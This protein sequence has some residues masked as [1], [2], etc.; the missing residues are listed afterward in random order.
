M[1]LLKVT[2]NSGLVDL[3]GILEY[4]IDVVY[5]NPNISLSV[6]WSK[7]LD[8]FDELII[9]DS[10]INYINYKFVEPNINSIKIHAHDKTINKP[11][12]VSQMTSLFERYDSIE[13]WDNRTIVNGYPT[14]GIF[15]K[16]KF[17]TDVYKEFN[18]CKE[19]L[20]EHYIAFHGRF[21]DYPHSEEQIFLFKKQIN[22]V[23]E[24]T[25]SNVLLCTDNQALISEFSN[26]P[27]V[28][29]FS[30]IKHLLNEHINLPKNRGI[31]TFTEEQGINL[32]DMQKSAIIDFLMCIECNEFYSTNGGYSRT[33]VDIRKRRA[34]NNI[35]YK[36][37]NNL[38]EKI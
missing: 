10:N 17:T 33:I 28:Y 3:F 7:W 11:I 24:N 19:V 23:V 31:H 38:I 34:F 5:N 13:L 20:G 27:R 32:Y 8:T 15:D 26:T 14:A 35:N 12:S 29:N 1:K 4:A 16:I 18:N 9:I 21:T 2:G 22:Y 30:Y 36:V 25:N 37:K 6:E